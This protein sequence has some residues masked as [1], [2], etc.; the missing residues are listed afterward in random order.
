MPSSLPVKL[1]KEY[2]SSSDKDEEDDFVAPRPVPASSSR[3]RVAPD[4]PASPGKGEVMPEG[5]GKRKSGN[6]GAPATIPANDVLAG[7]FHPDLLSCPHP[8]PSSEPNHG[9]D[10]D[11]HRCLWA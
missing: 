11:H 2:I 8:R 5:G 9:A 7:L 1:E 10:G 3:K 4:H 6:T